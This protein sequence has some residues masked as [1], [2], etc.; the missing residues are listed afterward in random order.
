MLEVNRDWQPIDGNC[1]RARKDGLCGMKNN[2]CGI[3]SE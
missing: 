1:L 3:N 2:V